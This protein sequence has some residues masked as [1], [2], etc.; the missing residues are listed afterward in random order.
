MYQ[1]LRQQPNFRL[2]ELSQWDILR[3]DSVT[4]HR[5]I[6]K[7]AQMLASEAAYD[8]YLHQG[9]GKRKGLEERC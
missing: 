5:F 9:L 3:K 8:N 7:L 2:D 4:D 1:L 6:A